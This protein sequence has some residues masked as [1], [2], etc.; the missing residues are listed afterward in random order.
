LDVC[1]STRATLY[2]AMRILF[3]CVLSVYS[4]VSY[5]KE[6]VGFRMIYSY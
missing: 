2:H 1:F 4:Q 3:V 5:Y 6:L